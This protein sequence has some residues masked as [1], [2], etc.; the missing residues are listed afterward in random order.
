M[1]AKGGYKRVVRFECTTCGNDRFSTVAGAVRCCNEKIHAQEEANA[2]AAV[3]RNLT[4]VRTPRVTF[5]REHRG[6]PLRAVATGKCPIRK[7]NHNQFEVEVPLH[8]FY[9]TR[10]LT[11]EQAKTKATGLV[12]AQ[13]ARH[14]RVRWA[15]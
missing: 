4:R 1:G 6:G 8:T 3:K 10:K 2:K 12:L 7:C 5:S 14:L 9:R 15:H 11:K 13:I